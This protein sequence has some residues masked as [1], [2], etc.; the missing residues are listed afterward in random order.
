MTREQEYLNKLMHD[1]RVLFKSDMVLMH[2][3]E[4]YYPRGLATLDDVLMNAV[5]V[6]A[7]YR[8]NGL[9]IDGKKRKD[10]AE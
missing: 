3:A 7:A 8:E 9:G 4:Y 5:K 6:S 2:Y 1:I 10:D